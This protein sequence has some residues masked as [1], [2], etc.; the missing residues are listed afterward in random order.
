MKK[1]EILFFCMIFVVNA[2]FAQQNSIKTNPI[3]HFGT[4][5]SY[6]PVPTGL[7]NLNK[8]IVPANFYV[9]NLGFFCKQELKFQAATQLPIKFR[10]GSVQYTDWMEGKNNTRILPAY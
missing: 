6:S 7:I 3:K 9:K 10:V 4:L 8:I 1:S 5:Y 2:V